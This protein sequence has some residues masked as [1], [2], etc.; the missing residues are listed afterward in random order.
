[1]TTMNLNDTRNRSLVRWN[2]DPKTA[3]MWQ[4]ASRRVGHSQGFQMTWF[5][6]NHVANSSISSTEFV[7]PLALTDW[8]VQHTPSAIVIGIERSNFPD[9]VQGILGLREVIH[10]PCLIGW[11]P[12]A[13][14]QAMQILNEVGFALVLHRPASVQSALERIMLGSQSRVSFQLA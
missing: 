14:H 11:F 3:A 12:Q 7:D 4:L 1:M 10:S 13:D 9:V 8:L 2:L 6:L 5:D